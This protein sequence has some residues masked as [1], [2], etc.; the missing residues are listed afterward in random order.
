MA[1][2]SNRPRITIYTDGGA[3]P[4]PG[5]GGWGAVLIDDVS[6]RTKEL[7]GGEPQTT[8]NRMELTAAIRALEALKTPCRVAL[9]TDSQYL[10]RGITRWLP[11]W[12]RR[13]W[14]RKGGQLKNVD[15]W[16]ALAE[17]VAR[18]EIEWHW[19]KG[20]SGQRHNERADALASAA[21]RDRRQGETAAAAAPQVEIFLAVSGRGRRGAWAAVI[22]DRDGERILAEVE[23]PTTVPRL[24]IIAASRA[25]E[26][27]PPTAGAVAIYTVSDYLRRGATRWL[28]GWRRGGWRTRGGDPVKNRDAWER[29][30]AALRD[31]HV[32]WPEI[33]GD[34][35]E[36]LRR[37][38]RA[39]R[40]QLAPDGAGTPRSR[41]RGGQSRRATEEEAPSRASSTR[42]LVSS[43]PKT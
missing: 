4:N 34:K 37:A 39:A 9:Y 6:G 35:P 38:E 27:L 22:R 2:R 40:E 21:I 20:H 5:P 16:Q 30:A 42:P 43:S 17:L 14:Q 36:P 25:L 24:E 15:L 18:H 41:T 19:V 28:A 12:I 13:G 3:D 32:H 8:N 10:R 33:G 11:G 23:E 7:S 1:S 31:R 29:L 26:S